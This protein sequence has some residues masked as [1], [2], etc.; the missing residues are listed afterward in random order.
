MSANV[1]V[2]GLM[3]NEGMG[4]LKESIAKFR[5]H[6]QEVGDALLNISGVGTGPGGAVDKDE[7][8]PVYQRQEFPKMI[9]HAE[10]GEHIVFDA[11]ELAEHLDA[12]WRRE[13]YP[14]AK[15]AV[16]DPASEKKALMDTN[17]QLQG[18]I[19]LQND[20]LAKMAA[21]LE[22]LESGGKAES[23]KK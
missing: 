6:H 20:L 22:A 12:G 15:V 8:R 17:S 21:R 5:K 1:T 7:A 4:G 19:T 9:Y 18:Q 11:A 14:K 2:A 23:R 10:K 16:L 13:P 3:T